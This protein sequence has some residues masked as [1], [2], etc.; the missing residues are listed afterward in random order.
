MPY[1]EMEIGFMAYQ[2][3]EER[4]QYE[5]KFLAWHTMAGPH[6]NPAKI[7]TFEQFTRKDKAPRSRMTEEQRARFIQSTQEYELKRKSKK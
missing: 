7:P 2:D 5:M 6:M 4:R 1:N 3:R